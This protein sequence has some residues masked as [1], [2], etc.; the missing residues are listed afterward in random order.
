MKELL[1]SE[2]DDRLQKQVRS[3]R[4]ALEK[5]GVD[6]VVQVC[7]ELLKHQPGAYEIRAILW[8]ALYSEIQASSGVAWFK[9]KSSSLQF[10]VS[11]RSLL[12]KD[13]LALMLKCDEQLRAKQFFSELFISMEKAAEALGWTESRVFACQALS[14]LEPDNVAPRLALAEVLMEVGRPQLAIVSLEWILL[15]EPANAHAQTL[16]KNASV[17]ETLQ[18]G[19]WE[20]TDTSFHS[21]K[22]S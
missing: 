2:L 8:K 13:P 7:G 9:N 22:H 3:A 11:T 16:L 6:Y 1:I 15:K 4:E 14:E 18:R 12:K 21:K 17:A 10:K 20:D 5:G 19:N